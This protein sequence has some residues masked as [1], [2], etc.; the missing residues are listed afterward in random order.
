MKGRVPMYT[1]ESLSIIEEVLENERREVAFFRRLSERIKTP[2]GKAVFRDYAEKGKEHCKNLRTLHQ[3]L[4]ARSGA[5]DPQSS[6]GSTV[7]DYD[8]YEA[9]LSRSM[10]RALADFDDLTALDIAARFVRKTTRFISRSYESLRD[11]AHKEVLRAIEL[12]ERENFI[13]LKNIEEYLKN[14]HGWFREME[15]HGLDGA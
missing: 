3:E 6:S 12:A 7:M 2:L 8:D 11:P 9:K 13:H 5:A 4:S 14:P 15:H 1:A 10:D